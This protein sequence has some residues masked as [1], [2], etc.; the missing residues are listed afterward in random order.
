MSTKKPIHPGPWC[1]FLFAAMMWVFTFSEFGLFG[2]DDSLLLALILLVSFPFWIKAGEAY[3]RLGDLVNGHMYIGL[4]ILFGGFFTAAYLV[5]YLGHWVPALTIRETILGVLFLA[6]GLYMLP[7]V[8]KFLT[9]DKVNFTTWFGL[10]VWL[11]LG[12]FSY[13]F[14]KIAFWDYVNMVCCV[15]VTASSTWATFHEVAI[16][17][18]G[19]GIPMG[20]PFRHEQQ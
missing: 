18:Y 8:P 3:C 12:S 5:L 19:K 7:A 15:V 10:A 9:F 2:G 11:L 20:E 16:I 13:F 17:C 6:G 14:P 1:T 4:G